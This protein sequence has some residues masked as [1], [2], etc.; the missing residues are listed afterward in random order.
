MTS[1]ALIPNVVTRTS[2]SNLVMKNAYLCAWK[3][4]WT[5]LEALKVAWSENVM[6]QVGVSMVYRQ[7]GNLNYFVFL[8]YIV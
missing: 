1:L 3:R 5:F 8:T 4:Q 7:L 2:N 6:D